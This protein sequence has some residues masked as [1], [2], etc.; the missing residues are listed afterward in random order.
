VV[1]MGVSKGGTLSVV[2]NGSALSFRAADVIKV[3]VST[4]NGND[5]V[6]M[7]GVFKP[8]VIDGGAGNDTLTGGELDDYL[9]GGDGDDQLFGSGGADLL[10]GGAGSDLMSGGVGDDKADYR[11]RRRALTV[12]LNGKGDDGQR[13]E[14]DN[15]DT[16]GVLGGRG[17]DL[18]IGD[19]KNNY[20]SGGLGSDTLIGNGGDDRF[21]AAPSGETGVDFCY[22]GDGNDFFQMQDRAQDNYSIG[23]GKR[24]QVERDPGTDTAIP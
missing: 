20:L 11:G 19:A 12:S 21:S 17:D 18:L 22:G 24:N 1:T 3:N 5:R 10:D 8:A 23:A 4:G 6:T 2:L 13:G 14:R 7:A 15:V 16:E 9:I